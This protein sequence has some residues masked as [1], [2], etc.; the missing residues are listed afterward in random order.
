MFCVSSKGTHTGKSFSYSHAQIVIT[1]FISYVVNRGLR[2]NF[3]KHWEFSKLLVFIYLPLSSIYS[4]IEIWFTYYTFHPLKGYNSMSF[5]DSHGFLQPSSPSVLGHFYHP[6]KNLISIPPRKH[7]PFI[8]TPQQLWAA[9]H[10]L[11]IS[12]ELSTLD[13]SYNSNHEVF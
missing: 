8:P 5:K 9:T 11:S 12:T 1:H 7:S 6:Q 10:L 2:S 13:I 3:P 4:F